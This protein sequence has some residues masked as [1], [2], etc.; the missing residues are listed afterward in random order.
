MSDS[1]KRLQF[2]SFISEHPEI[3]KWIHFLR[4]S[5]T[6]YFLGWAFLLLLMLGNY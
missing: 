4:N 2:E 3:G 1:E 6:N 5:L